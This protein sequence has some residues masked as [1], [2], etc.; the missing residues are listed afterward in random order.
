MLW[1]ALLYAAS[2]RA[3]DRAVA[4]P[5]GRTVALQLP[6]AQLGTPVTLASA[7]DSLDDIELSDA[8]LALSPG[9]TPLVVWLAHDIVYASVRPEAEPKIVDRARSAEAFTAT[10]LPDGRAEVGCEQPGRPPHRDPQPPMTSRA[11]GRRA[12]SRHL[13]LAVGVVLALAVVAG[14]GDAAPRSV[15]RGA[16]PRAGAGAAPGVTP[17]AGSAPSAWTVKAVAA[18]PPRA[19]PAALRERDTWLEHTPALAVGADRL[20]SLRQDRALVDLAPSPKTTRLPV[21]GDF[22]GSVLACAADGRLAVAWA[23]EGGND[24]F[25]SGSR[26]VVR[27]GSWATLLL[28]RSRAFGDFVPG[29]SG[30]ALAFAPDGGLL[31][32]WIEPFRVRD[33]FPLARR[34]PRE[35]VTLGKASDFGATVIGFAAN[36]RAVVAWTSHDSGLQ[37]DTSNRVRAVFRSRGGQFGPAH[38][39]TSATPWTPTT[40]NRSTSSS[41]SH[42][43]AAR[44][45]SGA[46][47]P[48]ATAAAASSTRS[49]SPRPPRTGTSD[50]RSG[51][52]ATARSAPSHSATTAPP[53]SAGTPGA[54]CA[55]AS[56]GPASPSAAPR[57]CPARASSRR[58]VR[59]GST[60]SP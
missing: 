25:R 1:F 48:A 52:P 36:G 32:T 40:V 58:R 57:P 53:W 26:C 5:D 31:V 22:Q 9:G 49:A 14:C 4:L 59:S 7:E 20:V 56:M 16:T 38:S 24:L 45:C 35:V 30:L 27:T 15:T 60:R 34:A 8:A 55:R 19:C 21:R 51:S 11:P 50:G 2:S 33:G 17:R 43:T 10:W 46:T 47:S 3:R 37:V 42:R 54:P 18:V 41:P 29:V 6:A 23:E 28:G 12:A 39:S 13:A 44:S